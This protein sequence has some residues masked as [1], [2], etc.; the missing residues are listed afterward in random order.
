MPF[1]AVA[2]IS[3]LITSALPAS[4]ILLVYGAG[5]FNRGDHRISSHLL[6]TGYSVIVRSDNAVSL[7]D[8]EG[9][10][11]VILSDSVDSAKVGTMFRDAQV[12]VLCS[13]HQQ[14]DDLGMTLPSPGADY[15]RAEP[16]KTIRITD[17]GTLWR[18]GCRAR[19]R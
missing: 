19:C 14:L 10:D 12:P 7:A 17:P 8:A 9:K 11:L 16:Q 15:G 13:E 1:W 5:K 4:D 2:L 6:K 18:P 3:L